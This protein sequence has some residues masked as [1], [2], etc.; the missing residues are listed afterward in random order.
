M[1]TRGDTYA[2]YIEA[3]QIFA[4]YA[5]DDTYVLQPAHDVVYSGPDPSLVS[6]DDLK[7]LEEL[8]WSP[9]NDTG[10][11]YKFT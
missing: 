5:P 2:G 8:G 4:K 7:R 6:A 9:E 11:F 3:F 10:C 1:D